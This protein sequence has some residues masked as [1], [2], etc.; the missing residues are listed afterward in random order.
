V[1]LL[2]AAARSDE[3]PSR[4]DAGQFLTLMS[5]RPQINSFWIPQLAG[6][7]D[8]HSEPHSNRKWFDPQRQTGC[9]SV[10]C[11]AVCG[12]AA[13][14]ML[15]VFLSQSSPELAAVGWTAQQATAVPRSRSARR[16]SGVRNPTSLHQLFTRSAALWRMGDLRPISRTLVSRSRCVKAPA[17]EPTPTP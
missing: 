11:G 1:E 15:S 4:V 16:T 12:N 9:S 7:T 2:P 3:R 10:Q 6:K 5:G 14:Q 8:S 17:G 13:G